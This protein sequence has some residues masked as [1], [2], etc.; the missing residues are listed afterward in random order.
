M[1][2]GLAGGLFGRL[3]VASLRGLPDRATRWNALVSAVRAVL[4]SLDTSLAPLDL[5]PF[6]R[7]A[8]AMSPRH[9]NAGFMARRSEVESGVEDMGSSHRAEVYGEQLWNYFCRSYPDMVARH[10]PATAT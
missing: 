10:Y 4:P 5:A 7:E 9:A 6:Y 1:A 2:C 3:I 8:V